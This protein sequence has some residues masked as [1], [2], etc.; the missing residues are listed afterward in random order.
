ML[1]LATGPQCLAG[2]ASVSRRWIGGG[3]ALLVVISAF[4]MVNQISAPA[5][6]RCV[7]DDILPGQHS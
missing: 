7:S 2:A 4:D 1:I 3:S 6:G 5:P